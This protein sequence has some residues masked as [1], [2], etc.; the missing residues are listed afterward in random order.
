LKQAVQVT[1]LGQQFTLRSGASPEEVAKVVDFVKEKIGEVAAASRNNDSLNIAILA[2]LNLAGT[3]LRIAGD[4]AAAA[5]PLA[6][7]AEVEGRL[8]SLLERLERACPES[9]GQSGAGST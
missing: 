6:S 1:I 5:A 4:A 8:R 3:Y 7:D 9:A 2:L